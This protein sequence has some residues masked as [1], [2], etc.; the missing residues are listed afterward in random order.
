MRGYDAGKKINGIKRHLLVDTLGMVLAVLV[1]P[2]DVQDR[3]GGLILLAD[4]RG[5]WP[6]LQRVFAD[7]GYAGKLVTSIAVLCN[8]VLDIVKRSHDQKGFAVIRKRWIVERTFSWINNCRRLSKDYERLPESSTAM[9]QMSMIGL[10]LRRLAG[11][12]S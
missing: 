2:A 4:E 9:V 3:K 6:R 11:Q 10:M 7:G 5:R 12:E 1:L 8:W